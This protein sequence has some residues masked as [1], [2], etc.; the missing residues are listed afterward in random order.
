MMNEFNTNT[1]AGKV[2]AEIEQFGRGKGTLTLTGLARHKT[3]M[4]ESAFDWIQFRASL[5]WPA[6][7]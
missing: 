4:G 6:G 2:L 7:K 3:S 1:D 5:Q